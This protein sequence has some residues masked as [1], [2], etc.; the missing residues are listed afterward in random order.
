MHIVR[1]HSG[2]AV[3]D[4]PRRVAV[5]RGRRLVLTEVHPLEVSAAQLICRDCTARPRVALAKLMELADQA[6]AAGRH[7]AYV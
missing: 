1:S 7:D 6:E 2:G 3:P 4:N 5:E